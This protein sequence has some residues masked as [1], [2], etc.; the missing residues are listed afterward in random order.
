MQSSGM[1]HHTLTGAR[2]T[3]P[4]GLEVAVDWRRRHITQA[5]RPVREGCRASLAGGQRGR[6]AR[7]V[8]V[9]RPGAH[10]DVDVLGAVGLAGVE[11]RGAGV[12]GH[13]VVL[14]VA[15]VRPR[16][17]GLGSLGRV[18]ERYRQKHSVTLT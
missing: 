1:F 10:G 7:E 15:A 3:L 5:T 8:E 9:V 13:I 14:R 18:T 12:H 11:R 16:Q 2:L 6:E 4:V 17:W